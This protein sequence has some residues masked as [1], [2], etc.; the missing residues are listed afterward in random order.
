MY[1]AKAKTSKTTGKL[2]QHLEQS[3]MAINLQ[4]LISANKKLDSRLAFPV[5]IFTKQY[6]QIQQYL[7]LLGSQLKLS[8]YFNE[9]RVSI[10]RFGTRNYFVFIPYHNDTFFYP[11]ISSRLPE[12]YD[13]GFIIKQLLSLYEINIE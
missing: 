10:W 8:I 11:R 12:S 4:L 1:V 13:C 2:Q 9:I 3:T 5:V 7:T 6:L